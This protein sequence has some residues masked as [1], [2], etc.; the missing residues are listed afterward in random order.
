MVRAVE[1]NGWLERRAEELI[2]QLRESQ[3]K[4]LL[5]EDVKRMARESEESSR[6]SI[7][8]SGYKSL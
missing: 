8:A 3:P 5:D 6:K 4:L 7:P 2:R 1:N